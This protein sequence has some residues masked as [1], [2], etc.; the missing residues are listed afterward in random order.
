MKGPDG[1]EPKVPLRRRN[2]QEVHPRKGGTNPLNRANSNDPS[3]PN[4]KRVNDIGEAEQETNTKQ[5]LRKEK[6]RER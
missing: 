5:A 4:T 3:D 6:A 1:T 2:P